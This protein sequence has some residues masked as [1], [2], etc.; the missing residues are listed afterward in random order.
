MADPLGTALTPTQAGQHAWAD[1]ARGLKN[2]L[3]G[4]FGEN[5]VRAIAAAAGLTIATLSLDF[6]TDL[7][8]ISLD[9]E[10]IHVQVKTG[11]DL[12]IVN[13]AVHFPLDVASYNYL[14]ANVSVRRFLVVMGAHERQDH[15]VSSSHYG[16][17]M[18][19]AAY[20]RSLLGAPETANQATVTVSLPRENILTPATLNALMEGGD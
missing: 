11:I 12:P 8:L 18:R 13:D 16:H 3:Q 9:G 1:Q 20:W 5:V 6:G 15:W 2:R 4:H 19:R 17:L 10:E 14:R 7:L